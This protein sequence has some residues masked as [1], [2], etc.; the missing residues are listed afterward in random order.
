MPVPRGRS[1]LSARLID[2]YAFV[3][4][5]EHGGAGIPAPYA[6]LFRDAQPALSSHRGFDRGALPVA[7]SLAGALRAPLQAATVSR[8][9]IDL[10][11]SEHHPQLFSEWSKRASASARNAILAQYYRPHREAVQQALEQ[12]MKRA[13]TVVHLAIHS[14]DPNLDAAHRT[15]Q[16]GLLYDPAR[17]SERA[18]CTAWQAALRQLS[19]Q[20]GIRRNAPYRG[21]SDGLTRAL[22]LRWPDR[23]YVGIEVELNQHTVRTPEA[24]QAAARW[25]LSGLRAAT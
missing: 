11:R 4:S 23:R 20:H 21:V 16:L 6:P 1:A 10:N 7:R 19:P 25:L 22:R 9:L 12:A 3:L 15:M 2:R 5:C 14:F 18:F 24:Q 8:L 17:R 13:P